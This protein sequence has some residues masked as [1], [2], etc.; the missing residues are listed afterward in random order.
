M[1]MTLTKLFWLGLWSLA[2][3]CDSNLTVTTQNLGPEEGAE[4]P[5]VAKLSADDCVDPDLAKVQ[6][7]VSMTLCNGE[8]A[9]GQLELP[10]ECA[11]DGGVGCVTTD[12]F[13]AADMNLAVA[14]N[15]KSG[16]TVAGVTGSSVEAPAVC[17]A[18][19]G[20][21]CVTT[22]AFK[23]A[24]MANAAAANIKSGV[25]LA[26]VAGS[27][28]GS[29]P[30]CTADGEMGCIVM[31]PA[32]KAADMSLATSGNIKSGAVLAGVTGNYG[33]GCTT[34]GGSSCLVDG[35]SY[36]AAKLSNF[37]PADLKTGVTIAGVAGAATLESHSNCALDGETGCI[38]TA[39]YKAVDMSVVIAGNI[40]NGVTIAAVSGTY[41]SVGT[42]LQGATVATDLISLAATTA[43]GS[44]EFFDSA[45]TR[46][47]GSIT[48][49]GTIT[50]GAAD[51]TFNTSLYRGFTVSGDADLSTANIKSGVNLFGVAGT[52]T[53]APSNCSA[54]AQVGCVTTATFKAADL[55]NL[56]A[57]NIKN[58]I[59]LAGMTGDYPSATNPLA[60]SDG[61]TDLP[62]FA[63]TTG[64]ATYEWFKSDGSRLTGTIE[65]D[66]SVTP[67][68]ANQTLNTGLYRSVT[69]A[70]DADLVAGNIKTAINIF[71]VTGNVVPDAAPLCS[72]DGNVGCITTAS[73]KSADM[74]NVQ[75]ANVRSGIVIAGVTGNYGGAYANCAA[76]GEVGCVTTA[77]YAAADLTNLLSGNIK[78]G[79]TIA[80][81]AGTYPSLATPL[82]GATGT[83]DL[84]SMAANTAAGSYEFF[85]ST[86]TRYTGTITDAATVTP[87]TTTQNFNASLYRQFS[88]TGDADLAAGNISAGVN[89][90]GVV[91][92]VTPSPANCSADGATG[93]VTT[94]TYKSADTGA[95]LAGDLKSGKTVAGVAGTLAN[96]AADGGVGCVT[97][98]SFK[99][100][101]MTNVTAGNIKSGVTIASIAG[102]Y[103]SATNLLAGNTGAT[104]LPSLA[105]TVA[106]GSYEW[107]KSDGTLVSGTITD[108]GTI[109]PGTSN[110]NFN[111]S[112]YRQFT[113]NGDADL[114]AGNIKNTIDI[115]GVTGNVV[116]ES[117]SN[118]TGNAQTGCVTTATYKSGDLTNLSA[119]NIKSGVTIAGTAGDYPSATNRLAGQDATTDLP[120]FASTT[121]GSTYEWFQSDG[122]RITATVQS[123]QTVTPSASTQT[124]NTGLYKSVVVNGDADLVVGKIK[125]G[126]DIF[127]VV[128]DY[129]SATYPLTGADGTADLDLAT[130]D[131]K[132]KSATAFEWF[133]PAGARHTNSGDADIAA[134]NI[135]SGVSIFGT[136]GSAVSGSNCTSDGQTGC[137]T[138]S[139]YKSADTNAYT[140]WDIRKGKTVGG[141]AGDI[142]FYKNMKGTYDNTTSPA[143]SGTDV[144]DTVDD[145][146]NNGAFPTTAP[147]GWDQ[148]TGANWIMDPA[149]DVGGG[150]GTASDNLCSGSEACVFKDQITGLM[151][152]KDDGTTRTWQNS[153]TYCDGLSY[154]GYTDWRLPTQK[155]L[156]QAYTDGIW[157]QKA[158]NKLSLTTSYYWASSTRSDGTSSAWFVDL[159]NGYTYTNN[160]PTSNSVACLR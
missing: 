45:G 135:V 15:I 117:H 88:V 5:V 21:G 128:G 121:G 145:Y 85:D 110:Q 94:A 108:A 89:I 53:A 93:C 66:E 72:A 139:Q 28:A 153:I 41:P 1:N 157:S 99:A 4:A 84:S 75:A 79:V 43:A 62:A 125:S 151:W 80:G 20:V 147:S 96:C 109:T 74:A 68:T 60:L 83:S 123:N 73:Y 14:A 29:T 131:A 27:Y 105:G 116:Q 40:K 134:A 8:L 33:P 101:N 103:P 51:L 2:A 132:I 54:N 37:T 133:T 55:S 92:T 97:T 64:G 19:G 52:V 149:N 144:W 6:N 48:D 77:T 16:A 130:F 140:T 65:A 26:G 159:T 129:P 87:G 9:Q 76:N 148:A 152:A 30:S 32:F 122:T 150:G 44:Y 25:T 156:M 59:V 42:P 124:F 111:A 57:G 120:T 158:T 69:V 58:G 3:A 67:G 95:F 106:A 50:P 113:V 136:S 13:K 107:F 22:S 102:D 142:A 70:G 39:S 36:K 98:A 127:G 56:T 7:D 91:G 11:A 71:N 81:T 82:A 86:G 61:T 12:A 138:T 112:V 100:A 35:A 118:C 90:F 155:E 31:G 46:Y 141:K 38:A 78:N 119:A 126:V 17:S 143:I 63:S 10:S 115:F 104:D 114:V 47:S 24:D 146:N 137:V 160:K 23:A 18:D 34:D 49:A 154:G